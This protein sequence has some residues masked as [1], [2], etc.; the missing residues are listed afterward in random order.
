MQRRSG[1]VSS[2]SGSIGSSFGSSLCADVSVVGAGGGG[3]LCGNPVV[4]NI[5]GG[6]LCGIS[7]D[8]GVA[9]VSCGG[10]LGGGGG[11]RMLSQ[12]TLVWLSASI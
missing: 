8:T 4:G 11:D 9:S 10:L 3:C 7:G 6:F 1:G 2:A 12:G 5:G